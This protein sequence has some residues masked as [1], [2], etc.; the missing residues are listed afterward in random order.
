[1]IVGHGLLNY[2]NHSSVDLLFYTHESVKEVSLTIKGQ[3]K[4]RTNRAVGMNMG[5]TN[6]IGDNMGCP[7]ID[8]SQMPTIR[9]LHNSGHNNNHANQDKALTETDVDGDTPQAPSPRVDR[10]W[11]NRSD[12]YRSSTQNADVTTL[13][14]CKVDDIFLSILIIATSKDLGLSCL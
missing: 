5:S 11:P 10:S 6:T 4:K 7:G 13:C 2:P 9:S 14:T 12:V 1:M 3:T 8:S